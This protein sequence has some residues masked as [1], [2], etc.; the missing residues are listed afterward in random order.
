MHKWQKLVLIVPLMFS[1]DLLAQETSGPCSDSPTTLCLKD[2]RFKVE[3]GWKDFEGNA[4]TVSDAPFGG[5]GRV[6]RIDDDW[7]GFYFFNSDN[8]EMLIHVFQGCGFNDRYWVFAA[9]TTNVEYDITVTDTSN[10]ETRSYSNESGNPMAP[11]TDTGAFA[12]CPRRAMAESP[13]AETASA[14]ADQ[15]ED[16][17]GSGDCVASSTVACLH[18]GRFELSLKNG[19][20][21]SPVTTMAAGTAGFAYSNPTFYDLMVNVT[22]GRSSN[23]QYW[24]SYSMFESIPFVLTVKDHKTGETQTYE[25]KSGDPLRLYDQQAFVGEDILELDGTLS[26]SWYAQARDGEGFIVDI[27]VVNGVKTLVLY[28]FTFENNDSGRQAWLIGSAPIIGNGATVPVIIASGTE[29]GQAFNPENMVRTDW[30]HVKITF[31]TCDGASIES[32]SPFFPVVDY[33]LIRLTPSPTG[34]QGV[35][36]PSAAAGSASSPDGADPE[37]VNLVDG[38]YSGSWYQLAR[39]GEGL[40]FNIAEIGGVNTLVV[41]YFTYE[42]NSSGRQAWLVGSAPII[43][44]SADVPMIIASGTQFGDLFNPNDVVRTPWGNV[45]VTWESCDL[46]TIEVTSESYGNISFEVGRLTPPT[47]GSTGDCAIQ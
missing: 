36:Q 8:L 6:T 4:E 41:F 10:G 24:V 13:A 45:K 9:G 47:I 31:N 17:H 5:P 32:S 46:A 15:V 29:F 27:A 39:N 21:D 20:N 33:D 12:T 26:G 28:Y 44:N 43:G 7:D 25:H 16:S 37:A 19:S 2:G 38:G 1:M 18:D 42:N 40:I 34:V 35:C 30:G 3:M 11:I 22:D 23:G 14:P